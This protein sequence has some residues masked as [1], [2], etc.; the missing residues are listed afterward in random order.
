MSIASSNSIPKQINIGST[1][2][3]LKIGIVGTTNVGKS[4]IFNALL[5]NPDK[6]SL[7]DHCLFCTV[8]HNVG[9]F[10]HNDRRID[11]I[12]N[13]YNSKRVMPLRMTV[14]DTAGLV[15]GSFREVSTHIYIFFCCCSFLIHLHLSFYAVSFT[16]PDQS[17][18]IIPESWNHV[19][20]FD[21]C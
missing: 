14:V 3:H 15:Q 17:L 21:F 7:T 10:M 9:T 4:S 16:L 2:N 18:F 6:F 19:V 1:S 8:D 13:V 11:Y 20:Q 12:A 5:K